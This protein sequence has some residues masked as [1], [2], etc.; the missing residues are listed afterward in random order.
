MMAL[1]TGTE[2]VIGALLA[3]WLF[4]VGAGGIL[5]GRMLSR[6]GRAS[7]RLFRGLAIFAAILL[8]VT[9]MCIRLGRGFI[10]R[11][12]GALPPIAPALAFSLAVIAPFG[13]VY[14]TLYNVGSELW[15]ESRGGLRTGISKVYLWEAAGSFFGALVFSF[16]LIACFSQFEAA[17]ITAFLLILSVS[18]YPFGEA[19]RYRTAT[20]L[21]AVAFIAGA[22]SPS[23]D[24]SS[25]EAVYP[26]YRVGRFFSSRYGEIVVASKEEV[27]SVFSGGGRLFSFPEPERVEEVIHLPLLLCPKPSSVLLIGG[28]LGGGWEEALKHP[29]VENLDC[30]ELDGSL[31]KLGIG[32]SASSDSIVSGAIRR[33]RGSGKPVHV[34]FI[35]ADGR[36]YLSGGTRRYDVII[37][38]SPPP[39]NLQWNRFYTREFFMIARN[40]LLP[41]GIF[42]FTHPS[43]ENFLSE[44]QANALRSCELT[45]E[46]EFKY[47][48]VLPGS[49]VHFIASDSVVE[50]DSI[51]PRLTARHIDAP[52]VGEGY[53]PFRFS[54][55]RMELLR[56][57]LE[58]AGSI[59]RNSD[60][61][62][63]LPLLELVLE[64]SKGGSSMMTGFRAML[65]IPSFVPA[66][67]LVALVLVAFAVSRGGIKARFA[68]WG[69]GFAS[70][71][72]QLLVL[73]AYQSFSGLLYQAIVFLTALFMAGAAAGA[74]VSMRHEEWGARGLKL[75]HGA[76]MVL[77]VML[78][79]WTTVLR[80]VHLSYALGSLGF[81]VC[82]VCGGFLTGSY[83]PIVVRTA[84]PE[85]GSSV[86]ATFYAWDIFGACVGGMTGG[87]IF[88]PVIGVGGTVFCIVLIHAFAAVLL[89]GK[90]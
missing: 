17:V 15:R 7:F 84:Y 80:H 41:G 74:L 50:P 21:L 85:D 57:D 55:D 31:F 58:R 66:G 59:Q 25:F 26:G 11:P 30:I 3:G 87:L 38:N 86:P 14:G 20:A 42:A 82:A 40:C 72:L 71:L 4:W 13:F 67:M 8:P 68:V 28:S 18:L 33:Q 48:R 53:L 89:A 46:D 69:V 39:V 16:V 45:L 12:P 60:A 61:H 56:S 54:R 23:I 62:P 78:P 81:L 90:W 63:Y 29:S 83:Y 77:A 24:R 27:T 36:F 37:L 64:G 51:I 1:F 6:G 9:T 76:F 22:L 73:L 47:V 75:I 34:R 43:S 5:G 88:F 35:A 49:T 19:F 65:G 44:E 32:A 52:F 70:F 10:A 79:A 2:F